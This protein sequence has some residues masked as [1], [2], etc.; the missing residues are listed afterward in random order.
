MKKVFSERNIVV[1]LFI[2]AFV[3]FSFAQEDAKKIERMQGGV[4]VANPSIISSP[5]QTAEVST[6]NNA[7]S[8]V[9]K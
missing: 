5:K 9:V 2:A 6:V 4:V 7:A 3:V 1:V 8:V